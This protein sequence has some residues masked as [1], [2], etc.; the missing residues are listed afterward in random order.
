MA[1]YVVVEITVTDPAGFE[2]YR[3]AAPATVA[4]YGGRYLVRGG[5]VETVEGD[6]KPGRL[7]VLE[8]D[9]AE[10]ARRWY[11][12]PDYREVRRLRENAADFRMVIVEGV[13]PPT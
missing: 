6:W 4:A 9:S 11:E 7:A 10:Q 8:F 12:S 1:A 2:P 3:L 13:T 5:R